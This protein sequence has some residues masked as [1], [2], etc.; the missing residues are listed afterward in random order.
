MLDCLGKLSRSFAS[1]R[2]GLYLIV[3]VLGLEGKV[4]S[5]YLLPV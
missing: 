1:I 3:Q 5:E 4:V 2:A